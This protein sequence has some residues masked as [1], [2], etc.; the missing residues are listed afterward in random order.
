MPFKGRNVDLFRDSI[1]RHV[2]TQQKNTMRTVCVRVQSALPSA[3]AAAQVGLMYHFCCY[4]QQLL[5]FQFILQGIQGSPWRD[6][7]SNVQGIASPGGAPDGN[8]SS[9][10]GWTH[11]SHF[12]VCARHR[13]LTAHKNSNRGGGK[14]PAVSS[15]MAA[16]SSI[17]QFFYTVS[18]KSYAR[19]IARMHA[20][21]GLLRHSHTKR[22]RA[23]YF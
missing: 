19:R 16:L 6:I 14:V 20:S 23:L 9:Q 13:F 8:P 18:H 7:Y 4:T 17:G 22:M 3:D 15:A 1:V 21:G 11:F 2:C 12:C 10:G 5:R